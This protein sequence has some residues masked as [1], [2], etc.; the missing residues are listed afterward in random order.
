MELPRGDVY[1]MD[2]ERF[3]QA[4]VEKKGG[5]GPGQVG[6]QLLRLM[7]YRF[8]REAHGAGM[9]VR[10]NIHREVV[11]QLRNVLAEELAAKIELPAYKEEPDPVPEEDDQEE[12]A[13]EE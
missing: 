7:V 8:T 1:K 11:V 10:E 12:P 5:E 6:V 4:L 2:H 3:Q 13:E 9:N